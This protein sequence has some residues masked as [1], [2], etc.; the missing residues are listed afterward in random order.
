MRDRPAGARASTIAALVAI[1]LATWCAYWPCLWGGFIW[2]DNSYVAYNPLLQDAAGLW[3]IWFEPTATPQYHPLVFSSY[4]AEYQW[5][6]LATPGYHAVNIALHVANSLLLFAVLRRLRVRGAVLAAGLF[7]LHPVHVESVAWITERKDVLSALFYGATLLC[8]LRYLASDRERDW[9]IALALATGT[10]LSKTVLCTLPAGLALLAWW[11][12]PERWRVWGLR[13]VPF[14]LVSAPIA[15]VTVWREHAHGNPALPYGAVE[16]VLIAARALWVHVAA[17]IWPLDLTIA[18]ARWDV[19]VAD[20][21]GA[22]ALLAWLAVALALWRL[23]ARFGGGPLTAFA[24]Y[25]VTLAPMLG[26]VDYNIM[27]YA[28]VADHFQYVA[29]AGLIALAAAAAAHGT[30]GRPA[31]QRVA[32][33]SALLAVLAAL[34]WRQ[35]GLYRDADTMWRDNLAKNPRSWIAYSFLATEAMR[36]NRYPD[37]AAVL[38]QAVAAIPEHAEARRTLGVVLASLGQPHEALE[39]LRV[40]R[41]LDP[42]NPRVAHGLGA[43]LLSNGQAREAADQFAAAVALQPDYADAWHYWGLADAQLGNRADAIAHLEQSLRL[44]PDNPEARA[45]LDALRASP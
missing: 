43:L 38:R 27:R 41:A 22:L 25:V 19:S 32:M 30:R 26:F 3:R 10:L 16:R 9:I 13:L 7:A 31:W 18:Y 20:P 12:A 11:R 35:A 28:F 2:D 8:W 17:L 5:W 33:A 1:A 39:Q 24:F 36:E 37:A 6:G 23:R 42:A 14:L 40:A 4:W 34:T 45:A 44:R 21:I 15:A 29:S